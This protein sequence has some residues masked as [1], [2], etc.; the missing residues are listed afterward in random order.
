MNIWLILCMDSCLIAIT[1]QFDTFLIQIGPNLQIFLEILVNSRRM[2]DLA[3][4][5]SIIIETWLG[6]CLLLLNWSNKHIR[7]WTNHNGSNLTILSPN[8]RI[9]YGFF[10]SKLLV[11]EHMAYIMDGQ[12]SSSYYVLVWHIIDPNRNRFTTIFE[13]RR[14]FSENAWFSWKYFNYYQ[15]MARRV[16]ILTELIQRTHTCMNKP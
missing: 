11:I 12:L 16:S 3:E 13:N 5:T 9:R 6:E 7:A 10:E 1:S 14:R 2:H 15:N 4:S 8:W